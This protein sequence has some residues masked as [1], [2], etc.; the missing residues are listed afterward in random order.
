[1]IEEFSRVN[2]TNEILQGDVYN[3]WPRI[4]KKIS[5]GLK[6]EG[7]TYVKL[8]NVSWVMLWMLVH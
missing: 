7:G 8:K 5:N 6:S 1:L 4:D 3:E 2:Q